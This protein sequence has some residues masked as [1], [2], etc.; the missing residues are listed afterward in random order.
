MVFWATILAKSP[1]QCYNQGFIG[2]EIKVPRNLIL[3][4]NHPSITVEEL[5]NPADGLCYALLFNQNYKMGINDLM[6]IHMPFKEGVKIPKV[7]FSF[8][9]VYASCWSAQVNHYL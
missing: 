6:T 7:D 5:M 8:V 4:E 2:N 3:G 1:F 9:L